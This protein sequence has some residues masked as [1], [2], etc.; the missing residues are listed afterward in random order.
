MREGAI[1]YAVRKEL[2]NCRWLLVAGQY[3]GGTDD[4]LSTLYIVD[5]DVARDESPDPRRH[6]FGKLVPDVIA[7]KDGYLLI[8]EAKPTFSSSDLTKLNYLLTDRILDLY[9]ALTKFALER[10]FRDLLPV[11]DLH[12][13]PA[14]AYHGP[15]PEDSI[16]SKVIHILV[17][18]YDAVTFV[19]PSEQTSKLFSLHSTE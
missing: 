16:G 14:I 17:E 6:S 13:L 12:F 18:S 4:E 15:K 8:I 1:H 11:R 2:R 7:Y 10:G 19:T 3:P 9:L 5:P